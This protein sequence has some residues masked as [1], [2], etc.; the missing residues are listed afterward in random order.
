MIKMKPRGFYLLLTGFHLAAFETVQAQTNQLPAG[1]VIEAEDFKPQGAGWKVV[2]YGQGNY[3]VDN[4]GFNHIS[5]E[6]VLSGDA[7]AKDA[8]A[9][10]TLQIPEAADYRV[11]SR[12]EAPTECEQRFRVEI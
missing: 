1:V 4:I 11:W 5:G 3:M 9:V 7:K 10:A 6:R 12:Y 8:K 2:M